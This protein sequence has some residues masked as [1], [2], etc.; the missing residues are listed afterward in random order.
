V[1]VCACVHVVMGA[2][3]CELGRGITYNDL[4]IA[5]RVSLF[6]LCMYVYVSCEMSVRCLF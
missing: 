6:Y 5:C 4:V 1:Y 2:C 3:K